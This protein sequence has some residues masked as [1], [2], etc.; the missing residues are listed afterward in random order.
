M[1]SICLQNVVSTYKST[2]CYNPEDQHRHIP[3]ENVPFLSGYL[4]DRLL[5]RIHWPHSEATAADADRCIIYLMRSPGNNLAETMEEKVV[6]KDLI[7]QRNNEITCNLFQ[8]TVLV[9]N[10]HIFVCSSG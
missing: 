7:I 3:T 6:Q 2:R 9:K 8:L 10:V 4:M 5:H 1:D